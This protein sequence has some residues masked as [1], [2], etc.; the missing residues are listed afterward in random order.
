MT[1][2]VDHSVAGGSHIPGTLHRAA[3][4]LVV[5]LA[6][7][8]PGST[9][10]DTAQDDADAALTDVAEP[11][12]SVSFEISVLRTVLDAQGMPV[13]ND[14]GEH[15]IEAIPLSE[16]QVMPGDNLLYSI[17]VANPGA[18]A[19]HVELN[20]PIAE[21]LRLD[22][23]SLA[24]DFEAVFQASPIGS[25]EYHAIFSQEADGVLSEHYTASEAKGLDALK[26]HIPH[27][28]R[29]ADGSIGYQVTVR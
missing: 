22:P 25:D 24:S 1:S 8:V 16:A 19:A 23:L 10:A 17:R 6:L 20:F 18:D 5:L 27:L 4:G 28:P 14:L 2:T 13:W 15:L 21:E 3:A 11:A 7:A 29:G 26:V 9:S 12:I